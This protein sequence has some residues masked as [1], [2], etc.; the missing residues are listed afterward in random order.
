M[1]IPEGMLNNT[2][3]P[4]TAGLA[5]TGV[6][7]AAFFGFKSNQKP[8][9]KKFTA[10]SAVIFVLQM[11]NFPVLAG[12]S[13]HFLG[14]AVS[15]V[16]LGIPFGVL[17]MTM[18]ITIQTLLFGDGGVTALGANLLNMAIIGSAVPGLIY[19]LLKNKIN[20]NCLQFI[21]SILSVSLAAVFCSLEIGFSGRAELMTVLT[22]MLS[23]H[24]L[25]GIVE[26]VITVV[27]L[28]MSEMKLFFKRDIFIFMFIVAF[29]TPFAS[30][31]PDGLESVAENMGFL[32]EGRTLYST[33]LKDYTVMFIQN[34]YITTVFAA[35]I[36]IILILSLNVLNNHRKKI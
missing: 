4:V 27:L 32:S 1:H 18:V 36:G 13:G 23:V 9:L 25:I 17:A 14:G 7:M 31:K 33:F 3:C 22:A 15:A 35:V 12:T 24:F 26:G 8:D 20:K 11:M 21:I 29:V 10:V 5:I 16:L 30:S 19:S 6:V 2:I 28:K 34:K